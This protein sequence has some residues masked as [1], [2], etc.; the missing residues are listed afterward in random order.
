MQ[1]G[2]DADRLALRDG[3]R[4]L[5]TASCPPAVVRAAWDG[6]PGSAPGTPWPEL[7]DLG[8]PGLLA[9]ADAG[10]LGGDELD[11]VL[12]LEECGRFAVPGP[13]LEHLAVGVPLLVQAGHPLAERAVAGTA[14]VAVQPA[15]D[16][17]AV[18]VDAAAALV[19]LDGPRARLL[20]RDRVQVS[21]RPV[22][23][24]GSVRLA[25]VADGDGE[26]LP[27]VDVA[28]ARERATVGAAAQLLGLAAR[29]IELAVAH[30]RVRTQF[31]VV[32][33]AQQAVKHHLATALVALEHARP[34]VWRAGYALAHRESTAARDVSHAKVYAGRA[35]HTAGRA[36]LQC[37]GAIGYS[38]EHDL[39]LWLKRSWVLG[40]AW[41]TAAEH[42][43]RVVAAVI[44]AD[45]LDPDPLDP[46]PL[47]S[48][49]LAGVPLAGLSAT[50]T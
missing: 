5:L 16:R 14:L 27:G 25:I 24:D 36:A 40:A 44:D 33:G 8:L 4:D 11:L 46:D 19:Q 22:S 39:Q 34:V 17:P 29:M 37:H 21:A 13:L 42:E 28:T 10:G 20:A 7:A 15:R 35:A 32:V 9:P 48:D 38:F 30:V 49:P 45:P 50:G 43:A 2:F 18:G 23:V 12:L 47:D 26:T 3:L 1:F 31:G 6:P 41:G